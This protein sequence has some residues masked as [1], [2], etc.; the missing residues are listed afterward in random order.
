MFPTSLP[1]PKLE[2]TEIYSW[3]EQPKKKSKRKYV[4]K[5]SSKT[6]TLMR[7][8]IDDPEYDETS[9]QTQVTLSIPP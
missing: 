6:Y 2:Q 9:E 8:G 3:H 7:R 1:D 4:N 5:K